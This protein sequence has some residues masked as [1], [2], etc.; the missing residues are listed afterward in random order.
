MFVAVA[1]DLGSKDHQDRVH[2]TFLQYGFKKVHENL[3][4]SLTI[5]E[6]GLNIARIVD[7]GEFQ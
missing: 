4:E 6:Q 5:S 2:S 1:C 7:T 3:Y